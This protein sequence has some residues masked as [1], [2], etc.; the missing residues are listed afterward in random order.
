MLVAVL[1]HNAIANGRLGLLQQT[2][3]SI[4][5]A[6]PDV[7]CFLLD[8]GSTDGTAEVV[9]ALEG[10]KED[11]YHV[12][13]PLPCTNDDDVST[14]GRGRNKIMEL[15]RAAASYGGP[16]DETIIVLSDDDIAWKPKASDKLTAFW[17]N[18]PDD[19]TLVSGLFEP[20][21]HWNKP[22]EVVR[23][24]GVSVLIR[25]SAPAAAWT[26]RAKHWVRFFPLVE[27]FG[28]GIVGEDLQAC[29]LLR[30][31]GFRVGQL[32]LATHLGANASTHGNDPR[33]I[34][35][36]PIDLKAWGIEED[37]A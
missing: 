15:I 17:A 2:R 31:A 7:F 13:I 29:R 34:R 36:K 18:A 11:L 24:G 5:V 20:D 1:T 3:E 32:D 19:V 10:R 16:H 35:A 22:C 8:N 6:F 12:G 26:F 21:W 28:P 14:P 25:E 27:E 9:G 23:S 33:N 37:K 4:H 30:G